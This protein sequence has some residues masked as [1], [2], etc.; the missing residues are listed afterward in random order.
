MTNNFIKLARCDFKLVL[1]EDLNGAFEPRRDYR[2]E[3]CIY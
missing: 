1:V 2:F 3:V